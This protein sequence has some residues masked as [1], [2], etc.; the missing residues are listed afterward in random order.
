MK[1]GKNSQGPPG[2]DGQEA[3]R[4]PGIRNQRAR[5]SGVLQPRGNRVFTQIRKTTYSCRMT[6]KR[7]LNS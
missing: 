1:E 3:I 7:G 4:K 2:P 5:R 6:G